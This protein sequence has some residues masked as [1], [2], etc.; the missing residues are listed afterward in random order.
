MEVADDLTVARLRGSVMFT[1]TPQGL[2]GQGRLQAEVTT[3][4][5]RCLTSFPQPI[6]SRLAE[7]FHYPPEAAPDGALAVSEDV[8]IDLAPLVRE[9][10][11]VAMPMHALCRP[12]CQG[13]CPNCGQNWNDGP[14]DCHVEERD[15]RW[16]A[17]DSLLK[18]THP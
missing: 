7:L 6:S 11:L 8:H 17:L 9:D 15:P 18:E 5:A 10:M 12:D 1:R 4:C 14:C 2:Y 13:L 3:E 16:A